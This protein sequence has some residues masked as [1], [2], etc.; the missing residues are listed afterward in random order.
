DE[1]LIME[2]IGL[3]RLHELFGSCQIAL[4][5]EELAE[6]GHPLLVAAVPARAF[7][8]TPMGGDAV[9]R[10]LVH[11][12]G[13]NLHLEWSGTGA[14]NG[15]MQRLIHTLLGVRNVI[16]ELPGDRSPEAMDDAER[17]VA[18]THRVD[19]DPQSKQVVDLIERT[20][21]LRVALHLL[22]NAED[23]LGAAP[24]FCLDAVLAQL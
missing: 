2:D 8:I 3:D 9:F 24:D 11:F 1:H 22:M 5:L 16:V 17:V 13:S 10:N 21:L 20:A 7:L 12:M 15:R 23:V 19:E 14:N 18:I 4:P 6:P